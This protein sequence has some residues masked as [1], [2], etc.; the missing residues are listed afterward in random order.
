MTIA[1]K[2]TFL[3]QSNVVLGEWSAHILTF[4]AW[5]KIS[6]IRDLMREIKSRNGITHSYIGTTNR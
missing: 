5:K 1:G 3:H 6:D 2:E 4:V